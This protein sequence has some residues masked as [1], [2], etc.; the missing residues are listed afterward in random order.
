[1]PATMPGTPATVSRKIVRYVEGG[2][3]RKKALVWDVAASQCGREC[4]GTCNV[5]G[6]ALALAR[7][8]IKGSLSKGVSQQ[9]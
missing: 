9:T 7:R 3:S 5:T 4:R 2:R 8:A 1:M 6:T